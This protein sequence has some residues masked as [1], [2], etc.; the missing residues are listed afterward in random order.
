[1]RDERKI[2]DRLIEKFNISQQ[3]AGKEAEILNLNSYPKIQ[4][5][6]MQTEWA[7]LTNLNKKFVS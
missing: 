5:L 6:T 1:M 3:E 7:N 2:D 4:Y